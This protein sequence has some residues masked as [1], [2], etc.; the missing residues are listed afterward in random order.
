MLSKQLLEPLK[1][2]KKKKVK[3]KSTCGACTILQASL[4]LCC[5]QG[6]RA[7]EKMELMMQKRGVNMNMLSWHDKCVD[8][9]TDL[10]L[11]INSVSC[12][13]IQAIFGPDGLYCCSDN[14]SIF[15]K[16]LH[17]RMSNKKYDLF[18]K[19]FLNKVSYRNKIRLCN[20]DRF[21]HFVKNS[22][23]DINVKNNSRNNK[24]LQSDDITGNANNENNGDDDGDELRALLD[25]DWCSSLTNIDGINASYSNYHLGYFIACIWDD[26]ERDWLVNMFLKFTLI[27][28]LNIPCGIIQVIVDYYQAIIG[29][30]TQ[31]NNSINSNAATACKF[32]AYTYGPVLSHM[33]RLYAWNLNAIIQCLQNSDNFNT[34]RNCN[35][36]NNNANDIHQIIKEWR[37]YF[38]HNRKFNE[39]LGSFCVSANLS[40]NV[41][42]SIQYYKK[43][44]NDNNVVNTSKYES[45]CKES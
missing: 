25:K 10:S 1:L 17:N 39:N 32:I 26:I 42:H 23:F 37:E 33:P 19:I 43:C 14:C 15:C 5:Y 34:T 35:A 38:Q 31:D 29:I 30:N 45:D 12:F 13:L 6:T 4:M 11:V 24:D 2:D 41:N 8:C 27:S 20:V 9:G 7:V 18:C 40:Q 36:K 44:C 3:Q 22:F 21:K 28:N 16:I